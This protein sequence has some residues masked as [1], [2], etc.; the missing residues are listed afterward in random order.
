MQSKWSCEKATTGGGER[1]ERERA[2]DRALHALLLLLLL[3]LL[4]LP[5]VQKGLRRLPLWLLLL[6]CER[7]AARPIDRASERRQGREDGRGGGRLC[8]CC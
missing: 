3:L 7:E 4:V 2:R 5:L 6:A 8:A 1:G